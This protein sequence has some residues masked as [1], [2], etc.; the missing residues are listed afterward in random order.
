MNNFLHYF[1]IIKQCID[2]K[3]PLICFT[4][5]RFCFR[6]MPEYPVNHRHLDKS[7]R[8]QLIE[9]TPRSDP[10]PRTTGEDNAVGAHLSLHD[11]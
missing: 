3:L 11:T 6:A 10:Q 9:K 8:L 7:I 5:L 2:I 1:S 4:R